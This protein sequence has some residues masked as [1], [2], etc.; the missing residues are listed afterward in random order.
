MPSVTS[1]QKSILKSPSHVSK[2]SPNPPT[3]SQDER[4]RHL[5]LQHAHLLQYRKDI[6]AR[7]LAS[8]ETLLDLPSVPTTTPSKPSSADTKLVKDA[9]RTF[10]PSDF[11][12]LI[13]ERN[14]DHRCGY[15]FCPERNRRQ[16][17]SKRYQIVTGRKGGDF[18]VVEPKELEKWCS[19]DC[20]RMALYLRVQLSEE[21]AWTR[22]WQAAESVELYNERTSENSSSD[23][24][25]KL[26]QR[27]SDM[28]ELSGTMQNLSE[29]MTELAIER[30]DKG[31]IENLSAKVA[32]NLKENVHGRR[33]MPIPPS[34]E[35]GT[36]GSVEGY[37]PSGRY[38]KKPNCAPDEDEEDLMPTI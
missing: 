14:I 6:E 17:T 15:V 26:S 37:I 9:L 12:A 25:I 29:R 28:R 27:A 3:L 10:Q 16:D 24:S 7:N 38:G 4:N 35:D 11:D 19:D 22:E 18:K 33:D 21:P 36:G 30:G 20:G 23:D 31:N 2:N 32:I 34:V 1:P 5:A 8:T 13:E